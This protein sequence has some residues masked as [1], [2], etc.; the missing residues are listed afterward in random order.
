MTP[1]EIAKQILEDSAKKN[2]IQ[3]NKEAFSKTHPRLYK[4]I[5]EAINQALIIDSAEQLICD[6]CNDGL[7]EYLNRYSQTDK[8]DDMGRWAR[9]AIY[10]NIRIAWI[11]RIE[12]KDIVVFSVSCHFPTI[13]NDT[14]NEHKICSTFDEAKDFVKE[15]WEWFL[16]A[17][18]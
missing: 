5:I 1:L 9:T 16:N 4:T 2:M 10:K 12:V 17:V 15:R 6:T 11:S 13:Q 3:W 7:I 18:S 8:P 14:A